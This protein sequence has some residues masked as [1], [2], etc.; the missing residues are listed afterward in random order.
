MVEPSRP[1]LSPVVWYRDPH[2]AIAW[3]EAAFGFERRLV[4]EDGAGGVIHSELELGNGMLMVVGPPRG[5]AISPAAFGG[6]ASQSVHVQLEAGL[7]AH[8]ERARAA[9]A[10]IEREPET[11][12]YGDRVYTCTDLEDHPWSFGQTVTMMTTADMAVA[13]GH[14]VHEKGA[15]HG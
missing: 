7:D 15:T 10:K 12:A 9:G 3:L 13:T 8:C 6:R 4:V 5:K 14:R 11:Q 1:S 2:A